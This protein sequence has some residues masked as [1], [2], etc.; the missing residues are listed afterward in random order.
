MGLIRSDDE[1]KEN[2]NSRG[3]KKKIKKHSLFLEILNLIT[4]TNLNA[5]KFKLDEYN[6]ISIK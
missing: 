6:A 2:S 3:K 5:F 4:I 1:Q